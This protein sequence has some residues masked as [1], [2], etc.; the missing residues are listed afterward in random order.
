MD[1]GSFHCRHSNGLGGRCRLFHLYVQ[2][3]IRRWDS[4]PGSDVAV[5][6]EIG[7]WALL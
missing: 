4:P 3:A 7:S 6:T 5:S 2:L 1:P